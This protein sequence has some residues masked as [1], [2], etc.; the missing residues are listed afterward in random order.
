MYK[1][2]LLDF[3]INLNRIFFYADSLKIMF[4]GGM[5]LSR[6]RLKNAHFKPNV[7]KLI[8]DAV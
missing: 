1:F 8:F 5:S 7:N 6:P 2:I 4:N 3:Y